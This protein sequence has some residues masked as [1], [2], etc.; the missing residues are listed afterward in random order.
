[1][2]IAPMYR[3]ALLSGFVNIS[4]CFI[5]LANNFQPLDK[6]LKKSKILDTNLPFIWPFTFKIIDIL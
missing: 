1:M 5:K 2:E 4:V 3:S 6:F